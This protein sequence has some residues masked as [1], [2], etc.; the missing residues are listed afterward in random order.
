M[1]R[2]GRRTRTEYLP[3]ALRSFCL[4]AVAHLTPSLIMKAVAYPIQT[5]KGESASRIARATPRSVLL[6]GPCRRLSAERPASASSAGQ[7]PAIHWCRSWA[8][9]P[10]L[11]GGFRLAGLAALCVAPPLPADVKDEIGY[12]A[13]KTEYADL[14]AG[15]NLAMLMGDFTSANT[16]WAWAVAPTG[17]LAGKQISYLAARAKRPAGSPHSTGVTTIIA[18]ATSGLLPQLPK[19]T[20]I[21][22]EEYGSFVLR[23]REEVAPTK[24]KWD[25]EIH[26]WNWSD[27]VYSEELIRRMDWRIDQQGV[28]VVEALSNGR[29]TPIPYVFTSGYNVITVGVTAGTHSSGS[30][31]VEVIGRTKP[32]LVAPTQYTSGATPTVAGCA[33]L[34][35][36]KAKLDDTL[37]LAK[38]PRVVKALLLAGAIK[39]PIVGWAHT[40]TEP[41]DP[42]YG[43]GQVNIG[44]SYR[45]LVSGRR[46]QRNTWLPATGWDRSTSGTGRYFFEI[47]A[48]QKATF[49]AALA[50]HRKIEPA[51]TWTE[52]AASLSNLDLRLSA[53]STGFQV[54]AVIAES[55][56]VIENVEHL[57]LTNLPEGRYALEVTGPTGVIYG[58]AWRSVLSPSCAQAAAL[59]S[60]TVPPRPQLEIGM[61]GE[62]VRTLAGPPHWLKPFRRKGVDAEIWGYTFRRQLGARD[63]PTGYQKVSSPAPSSGASETVNEPILGRETT[64]ED[65]TTELLMIGGAV[66]QAK[67]YQHIVRDLH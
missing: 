31:N 10:W 6:A 63:V 12:T 3:G 2:S 32:D 59:P 19:I 58:L 60:D 8:Q 23:V 64:Y 47:P 51:V 13:L 44:N 45:M 28:T 24:P 17:E 11:L 52:F 43:A 66:V 49:S 65:E 36:A 57:Y 41:L 14:P 35:I 9:P 27:E 30:T 21:W 4:R 40:T 46:P 37:A 18:G 61:R 50:W 67:R 54:G 5:T 38:D 20:S 62:Q 48:G 34:L 15:A 56:S 26:T 29:E 55:R 7:S 22:S 39:E 16:Q 1:T 42:H 25:F 33:G 53:A